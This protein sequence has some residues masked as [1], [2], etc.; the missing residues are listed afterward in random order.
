MDRA[1]SLTD[2]ITHDAEELSILGNADAHQWVCWICQNRTMIPSAWDHERRMRE[3]G[4]AFRKR[5]Y[6]RAQADQGPH[7]C[8]ILFNQAV[9]DGKT[10]SVLKAEAP[11]VAVY[12]VLRLRESRDYTPSAE[13][14]G[15]GDE[16]IVERTR[17]TGKP[18]TVAMAPHN[19]EA[20]TI[21][22]L[23]KQYVWFP[24][25]RY[26]ALN[27]G[28]LADGENYRDVF[29]QLKFVDIN[30]IFA[31]RH[32]FVGQILF[33]DGREIDFTDDLLVVPLIDRIEWIE[34]KGSKR[35]AVGRHRQVHIS[36]G[37]WSP[38]KKSAL[39]NEIMNTRDEAKASYGE[40]KDRP[41]IFFLGHQE[42]RNPLIFRCHD[43]RLICS[44]MAELT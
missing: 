31:Q 14:D 11:P 18:K 19:R 32:I 24:K 30:T 28:G 5:P 33:A 44:F 1:Y 7:D 20:G 29:C 12:N 27:T 21:R 2:N 22:P 37:N 17:Y 16:N 6:F 8:E 40:T 10:K 25:D 42:A 43:K 3:R 13:S 26:E 36:W 34:K 23:C 39:Y 4:E 9:F 35:K 38:Q 15:G 41:Y